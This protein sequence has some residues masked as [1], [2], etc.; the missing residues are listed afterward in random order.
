M[1]YICIQTKFYIKTFT[2]LF[3]QSFIS[4]HLPLYS[5]KVL[6]QNIY[7]C[8]QTKFYIKTFTFVFRQC[9]IFEYKGKCFIFVFKQSSIS[10]HL[11]LYSDNVL[12]LNTKVN[13][14]YLYSNKV[15]YQNIYLSIQTKFYIKTF[16]FVFKQSFISKHLP[17]CSNNVLYLNTKVN[18]LYLYSDEVLY[19]NIY[20]CIQTMFYI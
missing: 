8:I 2:F 14:L 19:Q 6:Y 10:K 15:L 5:N 11:S 13:V 1:F 17:L 20:L 3:K 7:L 12:Y 9:F 16:T 4:K 18:V